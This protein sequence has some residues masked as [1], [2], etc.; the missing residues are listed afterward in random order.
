M[1]ETLT[2]LETPTD[3]A[4]SPRLPRID[5]AAI[6]ERMAAIEQLCNLM[7]RGIHYGPPFPGSDKDS[8]LQAGGEFL[9]RSFELSPKPEIR[10]ED[11][12]NGHRRFISEGSVWYG[13]HEV[14]YMT[15]ECSTWEPK[16]RYRNSGRACPSCGAEAIMVSK[17]VNKTTGEYD[18]WCNKKNGGCG[19]NFP[20]GDARITDQ[21]PGRVEHPDPAELW[22][23]CRMMS[24]K[25]WM[26]AIARRTLGLSAR[27]VDAE[28]AQ[29]AIF[30][31]DR[32]KRV[33]RAVPGERSEKW[34]RVIA[35]CLRTFAKPPEEITN[36]EGA[37]VMSWLS[38]Q[39]VAPAEID[40]SD[41]MESPE[42]GGNGKAAKP[43]PEPPKGAEMSASDQKDFARELKRRKM[44]ALAVALFGEPPAWLE[45]TG[46]KLAKLVSLESKIGET[47]GLPEK[48]AEHA[49]E[50][51]GMIQ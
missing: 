34:R 36:L 21:T 26:V 30:D 11:L 42:S 32:A 31:W 29:A 10:E 39:V 28:A 5:V 40:P 38:T 15:A 1:T 46:P 37:A 3:G 22:H 49:E 19:A 48:W 6:Q 23:T 13:G 8:L 12:G 18:W 45:S 4:L 2:V 9:L 7:V 24:Q 17:Y 50:I 20:P 16:Y 27:F 25:R 33:L 14:G 43:E 41:F 35:Y 44:E 51:R 47:F